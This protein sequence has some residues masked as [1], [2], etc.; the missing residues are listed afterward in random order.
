MAVGIVTVHVFLFH[1][2]LIVQEGDQKVGLL[3]HCLD[4]VTQFAPVGPCSCRLLGVVSPILW[5]RN[6]VIE[7]YL[8]SISV[9]CFIQSWVSL[10]SRVW[11]VLGTFDLVHQSIA[12]ALS[13][14]HFDAAH[15][16]M[17][18]L[19]LVVLSLLIFFNLGSMLTLFRAISFI[20]I[21]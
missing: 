17:H 10:Y 9:S 20:H 13:L 12:H 5:L 6:V 3:S 18:L 1:F 21:K 8:G 2:I 7:R 11:L 19:C 4:V 16:S 15:D 14:F